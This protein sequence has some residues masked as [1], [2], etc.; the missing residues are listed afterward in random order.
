MYSRTKWIMAEEKTQNRDFVS[1]LAKGL[2]V[3]QA[4]DA[5]HPHMTLSEVAVQTDMSRATARRLLLTLEALGFV[6]SHG[7]NFE[8]A[9]NILDLGYSFL[10]SHNFI[11]FI[12][13]V[14]EG[15]T[16]E[17]QE[18]CS[19]GALSGGDVV[20]VARSAAKHR[21]MSIGLSMGSRLPAVTTSM[22]RVLLANLETATLDAFIDQVEITASTPRTVTD[23]AELRRVL[24]GVQRDGYCIL[25]QELEPGLRSLAVPVRNRADAV[26]AAVNV[27][28]NAGR[29]PREQLLDTFLPVLRRC[30]ESIGPYIT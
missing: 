7:R 30:A 9:P 16:R 14:I 22:G 23:K 18:S 1:S 21:L 24:D 20:Y 3:I 10:S 19:V 28:T 6:S 26:V 13:T 25:D 17:L 8:L 4:F 2:A 27:S 15:V 11:G 29:V 5:Q 12:Q